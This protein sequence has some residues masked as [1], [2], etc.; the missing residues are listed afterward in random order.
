MRASPTLVL[1]VVVGLSSYSS[2]QTPAAVVARQSATS[3]SATSAPCAY[4]DCAVRLEHGRGLVRGATGQ[5]VGTFGI[6]HSSAVDSL[7][8][9]SDSAAAYARHYQREEHTGRV[10]SITG[11]AVGLG[12]TLALSATRRHA[13]LAV[14]GI[15][16]PWAFLIP[17]SHHHQRASR[18]LSRSVWWYNAALVDSISKR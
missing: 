12:A 16:A 2:A 9:G 10:Y 8:A 4:L 1:F 11:L 5:T 15:T 3:V 7:I 14:L 18:D 6:L 17:A 13:G